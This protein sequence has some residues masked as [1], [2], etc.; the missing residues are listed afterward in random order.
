MARAPDCPHCRKGPEGIEG[1]PGLFL[2]DIERGP[3]YDTG[4]PLFR[5]SVCQHCWE[6]GYQGGGIFNWRRIPGMIVPS[7]GLPAPV[8]QR[9]SYVR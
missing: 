6:R 2:M 7:Y 3:D 5:C 9:R 8:G 4:T 1:H